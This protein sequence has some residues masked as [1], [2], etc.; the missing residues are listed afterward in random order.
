MADRQ[1]PKETF[2]TKQKQITE[3]IWRN[4]AKGVKSQ[5]WSHFRPLWDQWD[6]NPKQEASRPG[7]SA[8]ELALAKRLMD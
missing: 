2:C 5:F 3:Q 1:H 8:T 4:L 7:S 6:P